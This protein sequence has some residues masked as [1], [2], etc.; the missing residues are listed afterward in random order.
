MTSQ[1]KH[2]IDRLKRKVCDSI[3]S[4]VADTMWGYTNDSVS[5]SC[6]PSK[7]NTKIWIQAWIWTRAYDDHIRD[8]TSQ[9][10]RAYD[11]KR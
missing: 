11:F 1:D 10:L 9:T 8:L 7:V 3:F 2:K 6:V 4:H 5:R